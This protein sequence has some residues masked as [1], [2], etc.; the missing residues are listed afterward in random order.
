MGTYYTKRVEN[1]RNFCVRKWKWYLT[2]IMERVPILYVLL[3]ECDISHQFWDE[4]WIVNSSQIYMHVLKSWKL[5]GFRHSKN[6]IH[7]IG[8]EYH[9]LYRLEEEVS[10]RVLPNCINMF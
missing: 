1:Q 6:D 8:D 4:V 2:L 10:T 5:I 3:V 9:I 7:P